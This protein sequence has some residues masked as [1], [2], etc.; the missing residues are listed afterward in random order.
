MTLSATAAIM[1]ELATTRQP[2]DRWV[3]SLIGGDVTEKWV[4]KWKKDQ[5]E[6]QEM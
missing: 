1:S 3:W 4:F 5:R 6:R 2:L